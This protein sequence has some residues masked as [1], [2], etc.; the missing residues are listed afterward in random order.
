M[1]KRSGLSVSQIDEVLAVLANERQGEFKSGWIKVKGLSKP[2]FEFLKRQEFIAK[3]S[4]GK[5]YPKYSRSSLG[6]YFNIDWYWL[7][8]DFL[9]RVVEPMLNAGHGG[10]SITGNRAWNRLNLYSKG[11]YGYSESNEE[12]IMKVLLELAAY[13]YIWY[14]FGG[15]I[16]CI[17]K[18]VDV[19][20]VAA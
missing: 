7:P 4:D 1:N 12:C 9:W 14:Q 20:A 3:E 5:Y 10:Y 19:V 16:W 11:E 2:A 8:V 6:P 17:D 15:S 18:R 13:G